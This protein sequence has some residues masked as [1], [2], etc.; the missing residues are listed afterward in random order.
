MTRMQLIELI[1][2]YSSEQGASLADEILEAMVPREVYLQGIRTIARRENEIKVLRNL[3]A[4]KQD[5]PVL[6]GP[7][8]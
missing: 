5:K 1:K 3:L 4:A 2:R 7:G 6:T 8:R